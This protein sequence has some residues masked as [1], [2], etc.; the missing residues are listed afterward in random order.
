MDCLQAF[1]RLYFQLCISKEKFSRIKTTANK[2]F[3][4][5]WADGISLNICISIWL[6]FQ[7]DR[8]LLSKSTKHQLK[9]INLADVYKQ[10]ELEIPNLHKALNVSGKWADK[11]RMRK[12][13]F[14]LTILV[15]LTSC[16]NGSTNS[17]QTI[18]SDNSTRIT[19]D[20]VSKQTT[21]ST[22]TKTLAEIPETH[23]HDTTVVSG[24]F[25]L[26]LRPDSL[27]FESYTLDDHS[28]I[29][30][31]DSDFGFGIA[32]T[33]DNLTKHKKYKIRRY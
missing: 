18:P 4:A 7:L 3:C 21:P 15:L 16:E 11:T 9:P 24:S 12:I 26:F 22:P 25:I 5:S 1:Y 23:L 8:T 30:E 2:R 17:T 29:Y 6:Q 10:T 14:I 32:G 20:T 31:T 33:M 27:R 28:G 19:S 13:S